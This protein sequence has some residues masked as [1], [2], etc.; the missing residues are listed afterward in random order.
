VPC[1]VGNDC[2]CGSLPSE[3]ASLV[4]GGICPQVI[5]VRQWRYDSLPST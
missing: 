5:I 2:D 1:E 3:D 4:L